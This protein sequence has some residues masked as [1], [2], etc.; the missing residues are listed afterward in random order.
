MELKIVVFY[1]HRVQSWELNTKQVAPLSAN[2]NADIFI[3]WLSKK[4]MSKA[5]AKNLASF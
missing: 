1:H 2:W 3:I 5:V 4:A